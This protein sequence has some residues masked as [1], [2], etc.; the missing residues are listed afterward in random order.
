MEAQNISEGIRVFNV[1]GK[2]ECNVKRRKITFLVKDSCMYME[3]R[4][5]N[6][7]WVESTE[8]TEFQSK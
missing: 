3:Q 4:V 1:D 7:T 2:D 5:S 8:S 6:R